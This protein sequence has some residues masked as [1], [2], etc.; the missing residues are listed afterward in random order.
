MVL[1]FDVITQKGYSIITIGIIVDFMGTKIS[2]TSIVVI[3]S[4]G[5]S[6]V[7]EVAHII[8]PVNLSTLRLFE[9]FQLFARLDSR[10]V[11]DLNRSGPSERVDPVFHHVE[12][13]IK[14][15]FR[16]S[17]VNLH[18]PIRINR[19]NIVS[20]SQFTTGLSGSVC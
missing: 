5:L 7:P 14:Q 12:R 3:I 19:E 15:S 17:C 6:K 11:H 8:A 10:L 20:K 2:D 1:V 18:Y 13:E 9:V 4:L 16:S